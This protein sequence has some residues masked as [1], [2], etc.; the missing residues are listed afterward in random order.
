MECHTTWNV[1]QKGMSQN[2]ISLKMECHLECNV[3]QNGMP[4]KMDYH[5]KMECYFEMGYHLKWN[6]TQNGMTLKWIFT[7]N[8][9]SL[10]MECHLKHIVTQNR[11]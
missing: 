1:T 10:K 4:L 5:S 2:K 6:V 3:T 11:I 8:G 9:P 7:E